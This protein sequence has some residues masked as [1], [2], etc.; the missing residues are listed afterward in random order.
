[1]WSRSFVRHFIP[2]ERD[3]LEAEPLTL[4][5]HGGT[6]ARAS[7]WECLFGALVLCALSLSLSLSLHRFPFHLTLLSEFDW[8]RLD[9]GGIETEAPWWKW[10]LCFRSLIYWNT[11]TGLLPRENS[12]FFQLPKQKTSGTGV[13]NYWVHCVAK[14][15]CLSTWFQKTASNIKLIIWSL[16]DD[17]RSGSNH[18]IRL[19]FVFNQSLNC[20]IVSTILASA[21]KNHPDTEDFKSSLCRLLTLEPHS[22]NSK[23]KLHPLS[24]V[25]PPRSSAILLNLRLQAEKS[26]WYAQTINCYGTWTPIDLR[27]AVLK[28]ELLM[29]LPTFQM[30]NTISTDRLHNCS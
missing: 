30:S 27:A 18:F 16:T 21:P 17:L 8:I 15:L 12:N 3:L 14:N 2:L 25:S 26:S 5:E 24:G 9:M 6:I 23:S 19:I 4:T 22:L 20:L 10:H 7:V 11:Q 1:M 13:L 28:Y 29:T